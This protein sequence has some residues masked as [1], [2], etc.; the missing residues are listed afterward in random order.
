MPG[1]EYKRPPFDEAIDY[2]RQKIN[3]PTKKWTDIWEGMHSRAFVVAGATKS[4]LLSDLRGA[5]DKA[6]SQ[7]TSIQEFRKDFDKT[8]KKHGW[9]YKGKR[10]WRTGVIFNTNMIVAYTAGKYK[11]ATD[12]DM[13]RAFPNWR[14]RTMEDSAVRPEHAAWNNTV[15][16]YDDPWWRSHYPPNGWGCRCEVEELSERQVEKLK[17][18]EAISTRAPETKTR[19]WINPDTGEVMDIPEGIDPGWAYNPGETAWGRKLPLREME[20]FDS[21]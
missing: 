5:I 10:G 7:G 3:L 16:R 21:V 13:I 12:P 15:L 4:E 1:A 20:K 8:V 11:Q 18:K 19:E 2:F 14:Y 9:N 6:I 17:K